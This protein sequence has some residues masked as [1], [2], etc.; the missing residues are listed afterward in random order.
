MRKSRIPLES[1]V[2]KPSRC[3][4]VLFVAV[5]QPTTHDSNFFLAGCLYGA[6][7]C[8]GEHE[9]QAGPS[10]A[11]ESRAMWERDGPIIPA[12]HKTCRYAMHGRDD[13]LVVGYQPRRTGQ[14]FPILI[15]TSV[16]SSTIVKIRPLLNSLCVL[17]N[18]ACCV[19]TE[20]LIERR[21][22]PFA[23]KSA[24]LVGSMPL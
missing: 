9:P 17:P 7:K 10:Q 8:C 18:F 5:L 12:A 16:H 14:N 21:A 22:P 23:A 3:R 4:T 15:M 6:T 24:N 2:F 13:E 20:I 1:W 11:S 19:G